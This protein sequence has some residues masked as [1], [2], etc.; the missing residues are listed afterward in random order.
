MAKPSNERVVR[1]IP[2][3]ARSSSWQNAM[4][5]SVAI[6]VRDNRKID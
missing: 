1:R 2:A 5:Q 6:V 4:A 3:L